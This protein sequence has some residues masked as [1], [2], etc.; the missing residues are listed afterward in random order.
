MSKQKKWRN[1]LI[2]SIILLFGVSVFWGLTL[3]R[4]H[5]DRRSRSS[6]APVVEVVE[7]KL[8]SVA[9][10]VEAMGDVQA[11]RS[12]QVIPQV[13]GRVVFVSSNLIPGGRVKK[14]DTLIK[15]DPSDYDLAVREAKAA[16]TQA[17]LALDEQ[18]GQRIA[19]ERELQLVGD[20]L[21]LTQ[22]G[23]R[24]VSRE[25][26]VE[27]ARAQ[28]DAASSRLDRARLARSRTV[29]RAPFEALVR[30]KS[31]DVGQIVS[32]QSVIATLVAS[33]EAW[34]EATLPVERLRWI[35]VPG[36]NGETG[37]PAI[38]RQKLSEN[39]EII[40]QGRV[41]RLLPGIQ[42]KGKLARLLIQ[43]KHPFGN[44]KP[45]SAE[46]ASS[47]APKNNRLPLLVGSFVRVEIQGQTLDKLIALPRA[48]L[49]ENNQVWV[50]DEDGLLA[51]RS[52]EVVWSD[53][54]TVYVQGELKELE[55]VITSR[56]STAI[57]GLKV[58]LPGGNAPSPA[59]RRPDGREGGRP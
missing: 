6:T 54:E 50:L 34:V 45:G 8:T 9:V 48:A 30:D 59:N 24:L 23:I 36:V 16:V 53:D 46:A 22:E 37:A 35:D 18:E 41:L 20:D 28:L 32:T 43:V 13:S 27:N 2:F 38:I 26:Y 58:S 11:A 1:I 39:T 42:E 55:P 10:V 21:A 12:V 33:D 31:V 47:P 40:R 25:T 51:F 56:L 15:I 3:T 19:A 57:P 52:V 7:V 44:A 49:R 29:I 5:P 4:S 17:K 14:G